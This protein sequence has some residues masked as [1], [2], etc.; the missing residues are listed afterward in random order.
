MVVAWMGYQLGS[1]IVIKTRATTDGGITWSA[2]YSFP[3]LKPTYGSADPTLV[4]D[5]NGNVFLAFVDFQKPDSGEIW[6]HHS[7][8]GGNNWTARARIWNAG[9]DPE[10]PMDR[11]WLAVGKNNGEL[12]ITTTSANWNPLPNRPFFKYSLDTGNTWSSSR[13]MDTT[14][15]LVGNLIAVPMATPAIGPNNNWFSIYPSY[16]SSQN[17]YPQY[18]LAKSTNSG[19]NWTYSTVHAG[20]N[21]TPDTLHKSGYRISIDPSN[22]QHM[23]FAWVSF[24]NG[25]ADIYVLHSENGGSTWSAPVRVNGDGIGNGKSQDLVWITHSPQGKL[26]ATWR[27]RRNAGGSGYRQAAEIM[28]SVSTNNGAT[29]GNNFTLSDVSAAYD[30]LLDQSGNDF[31]TCVADSDSISAVWGDSRGSAITIYFTKAGFDGGISSTIKLANESV[32]NI[33]FYPNPN[34]GEIYFDLANNFSEKIELL[35]YSIEGKKIRSV[36]CECNKGKC[37]ALMNGLDSGIYSLS[38]FIE[39]SVFTGKIQID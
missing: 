3:H 11:P 24:L 14:L 18:F 16:V 12:F 29:W 22:A 1:Q 28:C 37:Q 15:S 32:Q 38:F 33:K 36:S 10:L 2:A 6:L 23:A 26:I 35:V 5:E 17:I 19:T 27:D 13:Y 21:G 30:P 34:Q 4:W 25:D 7:S 39:E 31:M 8:D 9:E 20:L